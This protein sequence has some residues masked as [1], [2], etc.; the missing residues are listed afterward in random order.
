LVCLAA[1]QL[2]GQCTITIATVTAVISHAAKP[3]LI[4][5]TTP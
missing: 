5:A 2:R 1:A 3:T 4:A